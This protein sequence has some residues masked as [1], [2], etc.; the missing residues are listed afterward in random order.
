MATLQVP[1]GS[2]GDDNTVVRA[3]SPRGTASIACDPMYALAQ[4]LVHVHI[5]MQ[6]RGGRRC[7]SLVAKREACEGRIDGRAHLCLPLLARLWPI[8]LPD[9][10]GR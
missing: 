8:C 10:E 2:G 3:P 4:A 7:A 9:W 6:G 5:I 1:G